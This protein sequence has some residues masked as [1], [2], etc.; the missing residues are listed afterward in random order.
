MEHKG[1][2][3]LFL[4]DGM[5]LGW[6]TMEHE[7]YAISWGWYYQADRL[8]SMKAMLFLGDGTS[9]QGFLNIFIETLYIV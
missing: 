4:W 7:G 1:Y 2:I 5:L 6:Q 9:Y 3:M 8:W